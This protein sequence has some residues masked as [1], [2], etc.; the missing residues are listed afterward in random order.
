[1]NVAPEHVGGRHFKARSLI[2]SIFAFSIYS[3]EFMCRYKFNTLD[4][5]CA[6]PIYCTAHIV[7][8]G[9]CYYCGILPGCH[10]GRAGMG[11]LVSSAMPR[12]WEPTAV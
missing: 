11:L 9:V 10:A 7:C 5:E 8:G 4:L 6:S 12:P 2:V 3:I 1:M